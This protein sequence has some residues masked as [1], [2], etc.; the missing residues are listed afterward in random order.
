[1]VLMGAYMGL[2]YILDVWRTA[3]TKDSG[4]LIIERTYNAATFA[5]SLMI[6]VG[7]LE[8]EVLKAIGELAPVSTGHPA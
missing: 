8:P 6:L 4:R 5:G 7:I 3:Q 2:A 1:M